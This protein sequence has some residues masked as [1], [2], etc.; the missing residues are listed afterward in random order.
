MTISRRGDRQVRLQ[1]SGA[2][3]GQALRRAVP[4]YPEL[5]ARELVANAIIHQDF[6]IG[7]TGAMVEIF[8]GRIEITNP[9]TTLNDIQPILNH[10][11]RSRN[12]ALARFMRR[13]GICEERGS[14][15]DK[16]V[17]ETE[18]HQLPPPLWE[19]QDAAF[20]ATLFA[21]KPFREMDRLERVQCALP[22]IPSGA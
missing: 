14:G 12:E 5:A 7:G 6:S 1:Q 9:G 13:V 21:P 8:D 3:I 15:I 16:V 22:Y 4:L 11:P 18:T 20:R 19:Q 2:V 17:S 10:A